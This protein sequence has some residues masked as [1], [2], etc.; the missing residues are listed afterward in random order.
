MTAKPALMLMSGFQ[1]LAP[2]AGTAAGGGTPLA[3]AGTSSTESLAASAQAALHAAVA[4]GSARPQLSS[5]VIQ[6]GPAGS[7][8]SRTAGQADSRTKPIA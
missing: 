1:H 6:N 4:S 7:T 3:H 8:M 5:S 2:V